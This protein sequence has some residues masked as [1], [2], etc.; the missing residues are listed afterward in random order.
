MDVKEKEECETNELQIINISGVDCYEKDGTAYLRLETVARGLG[1]TQEKNGVEYVK[2][3]RVNGYLRELHF[4]PEVGKDS[5]IPENVFYR[6]AMK[7]KN[8]AAETFQA[9]IA[10]EVIPSIRKHGAYMTADTIDRMIGDPDFGIRL[11]TELKRE[12]EKRIALEATVEMQKQAIA[13]FQPVKQY[14][15]TILASKGAIAITQIAADYGLSAVKLNKILHAEGI[16]RKVNKQWVLY[17][18]HMGK[19]YTQSQTFPIV[20]HDGTP[21]TV[22]QTYWTQKGR[23]MIHELLKK[24]GIV[25]EMDK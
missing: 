14:V 6:L 1:F 3:E 18:R 23:L 5:F 4:S 20:H 22:I 7:A 8:E 13:D 19:G 15:D 10:D 11:L 25:P 2:W 21:G 16:Q 9:K 17:E 24:R 12:R